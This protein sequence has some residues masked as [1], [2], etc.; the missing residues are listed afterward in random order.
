MSIMKVK[1]SKSKMAL[2]IYRN[3]FHTGSTSIHSVGS[4][5]YSF[6]SG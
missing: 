1:K 3:L 2:E 6:V 5:N 4:R